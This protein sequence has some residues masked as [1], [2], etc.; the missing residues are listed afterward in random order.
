MHFKTIFISD[1]HLG[2]RGCNADFICD[3]LKNHTSDRLYLVGDIIDGWRLSKNVYWPQEHSNVIRRILTASKRGTKVYYTLGNH[4][5]VLRKWLDCDLRFGRI[6]ISNQEDYISSDGK[7]YLVIH[8]D[9]FDALM[10]FQGGKYMMKIGGWVYD[11]LIS[12]NHYYNVIRR[13]M[14][15]KYWSLS[16]YLKANTKKAVNFISKYE[17][18]MSDYAHAHGY[19]GVICGHIH[20]L[21]M[22]NINGIEYLNCGDWVESYTGIVETV[23]GEWKAFKWEDGQIVYVDFP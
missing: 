22:K 2:S 13:M 16:A 8:G 3:F 20:Q 7:K 6:K 4:D 15:L 12:L 18:S 21:S 1:L 14:G 10:H 11:V 9:I 23:D 19:D 5:E 17:D